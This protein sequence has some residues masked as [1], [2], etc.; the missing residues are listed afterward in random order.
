MSP[1]TSTVQGERSSGGRGR[2]YQGDTL[3]SCVRNV[4]ASSAR[5]PGSRKGR[6]A[7]IRQRS[8][9]HLGRERLD[10]FHFVEI[11]MPNGLLGSV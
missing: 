9:S 6:R 1:P 7:T 3:Y 2:I 11:Q 10:M 8:T 4:L 5:N